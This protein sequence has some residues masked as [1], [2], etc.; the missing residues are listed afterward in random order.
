M[1]CYKDVDH[2]RRLLK[3]LSWMRE[4][5]ECLCHKLHL[6]YFV[7]SVQLP[8]CGLSNDTNTGLKI[9]ILGG[10]LKLSIS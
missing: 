4:H 10:V 7:A 8:V 6:D 9:G 3:L 1:A 5:N 2:E